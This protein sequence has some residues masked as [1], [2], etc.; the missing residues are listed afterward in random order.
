MVKKSD[1]NRNPI[2]QKGGAVSK[3]KSIKQKII[4]PRKG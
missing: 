1:V 3:P 4:I 2:I